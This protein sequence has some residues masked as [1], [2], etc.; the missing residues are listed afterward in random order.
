MPPTVFFRHVSGPATR[1]LVI[2]VGHY[3]SL[4]GG[5]GYQLKDPEGL[6]Q[7]Q[8][9]PISARE[10]AGWLIS[11]YQSDKRP[12][13]SVQL[14]ISEATPAPFTYDFEGSRVEAEPQNADMATVKQAIWD[15]YELGDHNPDDLPLFYFSG[16][17]GCGLR[18]DSPP[19][20]RTLTRRSI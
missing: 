4:P 7:L 12:L 8:S 18:L 2:G 11:S 19:S 6:Q 5:G 16:E 13:G 9:P 20:S 14:L 1:A 17:G 3:S 15:W 10:F